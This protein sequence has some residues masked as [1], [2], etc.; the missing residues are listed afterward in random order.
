MSAWL[1][2]REVVVNHVVSRIPLIGVRMAAY[3]A[4]GVMLEDRRRAT[5]MLRTEIWAPQHLELAVGAV[6]G[7]HCLLDARGGIRLG[8]SVNVSSYARFMT[9]KHRIDSPDFEAEFAPIEVGERAW[10]ALG[11]T[12][13][14][15][16]RI[17]RGAVVAAGAVVTKDVSDHAV[18]AG[19]PAA[20]IAE[21]THDLRYE[22]SYR[23]NWA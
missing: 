8:R 7:R 23:P 10:I 17:G 5:I 18:V 20:Q 1:P 21:R 15:G 4:L 16:V 14:G 2:S 9:A 12:V 13:L 19:I 11:A 6:V 3:E 22:L